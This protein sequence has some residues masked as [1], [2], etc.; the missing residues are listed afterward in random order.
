MH[1]SAAIRIE[2]HYLF[3]GDHRP[4]CAIAFHLHERSFAT[5]PPRLQCSLV[6]FRKNE[7]VPLRNMTHLFRNLLSGLIFLALASAASAAPFVAPAEENPPFRR[8]LLP[9]DVDSMTRLSGDLTLLVRGNPLSSPAERRAAAQALAL[10]LALEPANAGAR[11]M[12][13]Q[14]VEAKALPAAKEDQLI[15]A[16]A[17][18]WQAHAWLDTPE[19]GADGNLLGDLLGDAISVLNPT[20]P[21]AI[22]LQKSPEKGKWDEWVAPLSAFES[23][24]APN[25][26]TPPP[27]KTTPAPPAETTPVVPANAQPLVRLKAAKVSS[28][29]SVFDKATRTWNLR[30]VSVEMKA[31]PTGSGVFAVEVASALSVQDAVTNSISQPII[32]AVSAY[33]SGLPA[34]GLISITTNGG[35][36]YSFS[37]NQTDMTGPGF[38]LANSAITGSE[39]DA[40][41]IANLGANHALVAP[42]YFWRLISALA[43]GNGGKLVVPAGTKDYFTAMLTLEKPEFFLKYEVLVASTPKEFMELCAKVPAEKN[44]AAFEKFQEIKAKSEGASLGTYLANRFVRQRLQE[45]VDA[46]PYHLSAKLL[47][48]QGAAE[49]PRVLPKK[50]L[51]AEIWRAVTPIEP[52]LDPTL[53]LEDVE[54]GKIIDAIY[55]STRADVDHLERYADLRDRDLVTEGRDLA[56][57]V[58]SLGRALRSR[59]DDL[60][61]RYQEVAAAH[62]AMVTANKALTA[63]LSQLSGDP[64]PNPDGS[65]RGTRRTLIPEQ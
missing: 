23:N 54:S 63:K 36:R 4:R 62:A 47:A 57:T 7:K 10:A 59:T 20:D 17:R 56:S 2:K 55:E 19:S 39:P 21:A 25:N 8:D 40:T 28:V 6:P 31:S 44:A 32:N 46:A 48:M 50:I 13:S 3:P 5:N 14:L 26:A 37:Q 45:I 64:L 35:G 30:P 33:H 51:A 58:R 53:Q 27:K 60:G 12:I 34:D 18:L 43:D 1:Y 22:I 42:K 61:G 15:Y 38:I 41:V 49:R 29:F 65:S 24:P 52:L 11:D 16:K 9:V